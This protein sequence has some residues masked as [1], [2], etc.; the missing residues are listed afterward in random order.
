MKK[1]LMITVALLFWLIIIIQWI[2]VIGLKGFAIKELDKIVNT[3]VEIDK[4][5]INLI[6]GAVSFSKLSIYNPTGFSTE[7][8]LT[9]DKG[10][11]RI[12]LLSLIQGRPEIKKIILNKVAVNIEIAKS[13]VSN[14]SV[15]FKKKTPAPEHTV[16]MAPAKE[17]TGAFKIDEIVIRD[18]IF[19]FL[20]YKV[21]P[22]GAVALFNDINIS[23]LNLRPPEFP[24][25]KPT[26]IKCEAGLPAKNLSGKINLIANGDF[27]S[28]QINFEANLAAN[29]ISLPYFMSFYVN[30]APVYAKDGQFDL[31]STAECRNNTLDATQEVAIKNLELTINKTNLGDNLVFGQPVL[32]VVNLF[33]NS[34]GAMNFAF[35]ITG[36]LADPEFHLAEAMKK[37]L[38]KSIG[39]AIATKLSDLSGIIMDKVGE[40]AKEAA[41][42][43]EGG[44]QI[45]KGVFKQIL[46]PDNSEIKK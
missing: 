3:K 4:V 28:E 35:K 10:Y 38:V 42:A 1:F 2:L 36:T 44:T 6:K 29:T 12:N 8:F 19:E 27:L 46:N 13:T 45:L 11:I 17:K 24:N 41:K 26:S 7:R 14:T 31:R 34:Q 32:S 9:I 18:G 33:T 37:A 39:N 16:K 43:P 23:V 22:D 15:I 20:N 25:E 40:A 5:G 21:N 30:T